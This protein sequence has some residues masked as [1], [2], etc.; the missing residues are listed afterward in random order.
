MWDLIERRSDDNVVNCIWIFKVKENI[1]GMVDRLKTHLIANGTNQIEGLDDYHETFFLVNK[2]AS[3]HIYLSLAITNGWKLHQIDINNMFLNGILE[4]KILQ[5]QTS[6]FVDS[7]YP[8][9][10]CRLSKSICGLKLSLH[11]WF[12]QL[13]DMLTSMGYLESVANPWLFFSKDNHTIGL[14]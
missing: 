1:D 14:C 4:E 3:I 13:R 11:V 8:H 9:Q 7:N 10:V 5:R 6:G 12:C 2:P